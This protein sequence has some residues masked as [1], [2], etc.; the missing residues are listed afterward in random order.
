MSVNSTFF[1]SPK[2]GW[3]TRTRIQLSL[4]LL[5]LDSLL[6]TFIG[7]L[8]IVVE[9]IHRPTLSSAGWRC[10]RSWWSRY[11]RLW[12]TGRQTGQSIG[13]IFLIRHIGRTMLYTKASRLNLVVIHRPPKSRVLYVQYTWWVWKPVEWDHGS[14]WEIVDLWWF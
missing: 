7:R 8:T 3:K 9:L 10:S 1:L 4:I 2:R 6:Y 13:E 5:R 11:R 12:Q 14:S